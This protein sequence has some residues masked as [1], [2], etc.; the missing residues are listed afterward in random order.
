MNNRV[1]FD[2]TAQGQR[3]QKSYR[4]LGDFEFRAT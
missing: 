1:E 2:V 3:R 4:W